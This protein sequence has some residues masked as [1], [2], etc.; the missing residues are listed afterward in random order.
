M[1]DPVAFL[2]EIGTEYETRGRRL[3]TACPWCRAEGRDTDGDHW[4]FAPDGSHYGC[5]RDRSHGGSLTN[6]VR[7][8]ANW[9]VEQATAY[10][11]GA[12]GTSPLETLL[13]RSVA[14]GRPVP[15]PAR[16]PLAV[17]PEFRRIEQTGLARLGWSYLATRGFPDVTGLALRYQLRMALSGRWANRVI[18]PIWNGPAL[19]GWTARAIGRN[20]L[21]YL[22]EPEGGGAKD[23]PFNGQLA[24]GGRLLFL[25]EGPFDALKLDWFGYP[26]GVNAIALMGTSATPGQVA[27]LAGLVPLY[28]RTV[29]LLDSAERGASRRLAASLPGLSVEVGQL[30]RKWKDPGALSEE[31]CRELFGAYV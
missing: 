29:I 15:P 11:G 1:F 19:L 8:F 6:V 20:G 3:V 31:A 10:L 16:E 26:R 22:T 30:D 25:V 21:R 13:A 7:R 9:S 28:E 23:V 5:W 27:V 2:T 18:L 4:T 14:L 12:V 24:A 17:P